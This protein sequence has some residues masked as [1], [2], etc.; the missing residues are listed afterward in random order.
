MLRDERA[1]TAAG[2]T[3]GTAVLGTVSP[4]FDLTARLEPSAA[5]ATGGLR[6]VTSV[7][8]AEYLD[9]SID[10]VAGEL[11]VDRDHASL[12]PRARGGTYR[13]PCPEAKTE[14]GAPV[15]L[16]LVVDRSVAELYLPSGRTLTLRFYP[17]GGGPWRIEARSAGEGG[18]GYTV[19]AWNLRPYVMR[20]T[21]GAGAE[22]TLT[23]VGLVHP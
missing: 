12:D 8:G 11:V 23:S 17:T 13:V 5:G 2:E 19:R 21:G 6:L 16:R 1:V 14:S 7:D 20:H 4:S 3:T 18:L 22:T 10:P 15:E 9:I